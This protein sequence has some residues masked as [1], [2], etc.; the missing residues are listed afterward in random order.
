[1]GGRTRPLRNKAMVPISLYPQNCVDKEADQG[2]LSLGPRASRVPPGSG[3][4]PLLSQPCSTHKPSSH[5]GK[6]SY[7]SKGEGS[8]CAPNLRCTYVHH[9]GAA[10]TQPATQT[11]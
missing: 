9:V 1:M 3:A 2:S 10:P 6:H 5:C 8:R 4:T 7:I 11:C